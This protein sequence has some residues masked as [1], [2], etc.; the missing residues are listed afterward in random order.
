MLW[1]HYLVGV[2]HFAEFRKNQAVTVR[3]ANKS[4]KK[5]LFR[6]GEENGKVIQNPYA[7]LEAQQELISSS[8]IR[9]PVPLKCL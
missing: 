7:G 9:C 4:P 6:N 8:N 5:P 3:N 2:S 1:I